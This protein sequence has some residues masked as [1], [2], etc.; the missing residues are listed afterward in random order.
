MMQ[1]A[2]VQAA[3]RPL[4][5]YPDISLQDKQHQIEIRKLFHDDHLSRQ[6][7]IAVVE[8]PR[9]ADCILVFA[10]GNEARNSE[11]ARKHGIPTLVYDPID[12]PTGVAPGLYCSL[13]R[14]LFDARRHRTFCYPVVYNECVEAFPQNAAQALFCFAGGF[15]SGLRQRLVAWMQQTDFAHPV[16]LLVQT[17]PWQQMFDRSGIPEKKRYAEI[18]KESRF[19]LCPRG[20][21][22]GSIRLFEVLKAGRVP[23]IISDEYVPPSGV[24]WSSCSITVKERN[25]RKIPEILEAHL[26]KWP[27]M[28]ENARKVSL[29]HFEGPG[30]LDSLGQSIRHILAHDRGPSF[31]HRARI[32]RYKTQKNCRRIAGS[33]LRM[34]RQKASMLSRGA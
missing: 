10:H 32:M 15:S 12:C 7:Q 20:N 16:R 22:V 23:V 24:D 1:N 3:A 17:G 28:A 9:E 2:L 6:G 13:P 11:L 4:A 5:I 26:D 18:L 25:F 29:E 31:G 33:L 19:V 14:Q 27:T 34:L 8:D 21:G 30:L